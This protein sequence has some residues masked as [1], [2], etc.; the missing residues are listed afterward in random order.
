MNEF[1]RV[2]VII[3]C[4]NEESFIGQCL[5]S[6]I[7]NDYP[8]DK[9]EIIAVDGL[10]EDGTKEIIK[11]Y[12]KIFPNIKLFDNPQRTVPF[13]LNIGI[14]NARGDIIV[15]MD[16]HNTYE[17]DYISKCVKYLKEYD[18][19]NVGGISRTL[20]GDTT[21]IAQ[22]IAIAL[23][24]PFGVGNAYFRIGSREPK[25]VDT[26]PFGCYK[27][28]VFE[29]IGLFNENLVRNQDIEFNIRLKNAGGKILLVPDII[30]YYHARPTLKVFAK[31]NF[32][33]GFWVLYSLRF[34]KLPFSVRHLIPFLFV[35]SL[36]G[37]IIFSIVFN[38][39][40]YLFIF[41]ALSYLSLNM[42]F[43][44]KLSLKYGFKYFILLILSFM[45]LHFSYGAGS[46]CGL[47]R[48]LTSKIR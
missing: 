30:S 33:N 40:I 35:L 46:I 34:A 26:V 14:I 41:V 15:R 23:S 28:S 4:R 45:T 16:A 42:F 44:F 18:A 19:D 36:S 27:K 20:P 9:L 11:K 5:D 8:K 37:G 48:L 1:P 13:A 6:I 47:I 39:L 10:S 24:N 3:P 12:T 43:S 21:Q 31:N 7:A 29:K 17:K 38:P 22:S 2:S 25:Y 32:W